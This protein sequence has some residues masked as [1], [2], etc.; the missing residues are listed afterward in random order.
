MKWEYEDIIESLQND[1]VLHYK[2]RQHYLENDNEVDAD[3]EGAVC[4]YIFDKLKEITGGTPT[5]VADRLQDLID[6]VFEFD[7]QSEPPY[8]LTIGKKY[9]LESDILYS[10]YNSFACMFDEDDLNYLLE[11][12]VEVSG[13]NVYIPKGTHMI[14]KGC[15]RGGSGWP[16]FVIHDFEFDFSGD[17]IKLRKVD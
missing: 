9:C 4:D 5:D 3:W 13:D 14:Y 2:N 17:P 6:G 1:Y 15:E 16:T 8:P 11:E 10:D 7:P 12:V